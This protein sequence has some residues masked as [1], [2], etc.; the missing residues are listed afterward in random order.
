VTVVGFVGAAAVGGL[1]RWAAGARLPPPLGTLAVNLVGAFVLGFLAGAGP[2][3]RTLVGVAF[4]GSLT[5]FST[6]MVEL[7][8]LANRRPGAAAGYAAV[9]FLGGTALAWLGLRLA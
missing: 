5:T 9:T 8:D 1:V 4:L 2:T 6:V 3:A 7:R